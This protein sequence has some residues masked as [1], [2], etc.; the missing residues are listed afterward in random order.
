M[1]DQEGS[2]AVNSIPNNL[3]LQLTSFVGRERELAEVARLLLTTRLLTLTGA[4]GSGKTRLALEVASQ[5][6]KGFPGGVWIEELAALSDQELVL[7]VTASALGVREAPGHALTELLIDYLKPRH[8]LLVLD[9]CEHLIEACAQLGETLLQA[10]PRLRILA[11]SREPLHIAGELIWLVPGLSIPDLR[12]LSTPENLLRF[13]AVQLFSERAKTALPTFEV[14]ADNAAALAQVCSRLD[15]IPLAIELAAARVR[16][17]S[18]EQIASRLD[19]SLRLLAG[20]YRTGLAR[21]QTL[22]ATLDW[23]YDLLTDKERRS[24]QRLAVFAGGFSLEAAEVV[25]AGEGIEPDEVLDLLTALV[26]RSLLI[27]DKQPG[28]APRYRLLEPI[29]Q[30]SAERLRSSGEE[31]I[32]RKLHRDWYL[33]RAMSA[34]PQLHGPQQVVW[35]DWLETEHDN[36]RAALAWSQREPE[37]AEPGLQLAISLNL[38]WQMRGYLSEGR[39]WLEIMLFRGSQA[40]AA[41]R[42]RALSAAGFLANI[43]GDFAQ[44][45]AFLE[46]SLAMYQDL[47][48][49]SS[50]GWQLMYLAYLAQHERDF[51]C[52][53]SLARQSLS[54]QRAVE[55]PWGIAGSLSCL[56]D[57]VFIQGD[58]TRAYTLLEE[59]VALARAVG[60][61]WSLGRRLVRMGQVAQAQGNLEHAQ[62]SIQEGL[63][64]CKEAGDYWGVIKALVGSAG[65]AV[66]RSEPERAARLLGAV[67]MRR[68]TIGATLEV[69]DQLEY[70]RNITATQAALSAQQFSQAW[71][72]GQAMSLEDAINY[73]QEKVEA[74][75]EAST[76]QGALSPAG[77][78]RREIEV[79][80]FIAVGKSNQQI[81]EEL[82]LS[83]R[84]VE[85]HTYNIYAKIGVS[86]ST[87]RAAATAYAF[88]HGLA[89]A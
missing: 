45:R 4:G 59:A 12:R 55:D 48:D 8:V 82:V 84:T 21:H 47:A 54:L 66:R 20:G 74:L 16:V 78:T 43:S 38:F 72:Q 35:V 30:Y 65:V 85:R 42:A 23:S 24:F 63:A 36:L 71:E 49:S 14:R 29:R 76:P 5:L 70:G 9:N 75:H 11:T 1:P 67:E 88:S 87:A 83:I 61:W 64:T 79:L 77:L 60:N 73:G 25:C 89:Q 44:A 22:K 40:P 46:Q 19:D 41:L 56:A 39:R 10:C 80:R 53:A 2:V 31:A 50:I 34:D 32:L 3:P 37:G 15:G 26:D 68:N 86:G 13:E 57:I 17:L 6:L 62:A 33:A 7:Q 28:R 69:V 58:I 81:A 51:S 52:A 18:V 27:V